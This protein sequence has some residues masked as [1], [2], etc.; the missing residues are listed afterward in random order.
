MRPPTA[1]VG[2]TDWEWFSQLRQ[3]PGVDE[4]NFWQPS[5]RGFLALEPG[6]PFLFKLHSPRNRIVGCGIFARHVQLPVSMAWEAF[7]A[8]NGVRSLVEMRRRVERYRRTA[9]ATPSDYEV[10]CILLE[11]PTFFE[12]TEWIE[13]PDWKSSIQVGRRYRLD[14]EPGLSLWPKVESLMQ[15]SYVGEMAA[16]PMLREL[17]APT[18]WSSGI[19]ASSSGPGVFSGGHRRCVW[20]QMRGYR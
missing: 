6:E 1:F 15:A 4:V 17:G 2:I 7:G 12:E 20:P 13:A 3:L 11:Q 9:A 19:Y 5:P 16:A 14:E 18:V 10:G 8:K